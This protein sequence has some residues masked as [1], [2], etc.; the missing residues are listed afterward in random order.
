VPAAAFDLRRAWRLSP[1]VALRAEDFGALAYHF[2]TRRLS[3]L[4]SRQLLT[5]V[6]SLGDHPDAMAACEAAG[7]TAD[8]IPQFTR[9]LAQ[10][11]E[12]N[13]IVADGA[14]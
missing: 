12:T 2:Q 8:E 1:S 7:V 4:K 14:P 13:M 11:A 3:F 10:L 9:A 6:S 5:V